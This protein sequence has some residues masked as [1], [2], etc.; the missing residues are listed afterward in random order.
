MK[1]TKWKAA[2]ISTGRDLKYLRSSVFSYLKKRKFEVI[3]YE[4]TGYPVEPSVSAHEACIVAL[5]ECDI[6]IL[7]IDK[8]YGTFFLDENIS[9]TETEYN[10][11]AKL[12]KIIIP[13]INQKADQ[14]RN[15]ILKAIKQIKEKKG[16]TE[17]KAK[18]LVSPHYVDSWNVIDFITN[19]YDADKDN[20][21]IK[22]ST[23]DDLLPNLESRLKGL[24]RAIYTKC[25]ESQ[26][27][28]IKRQK[29]VTLSL[30]LDDIIN[31]GY[32][33]EPEYEVQSGVEKGGLLQD[34]N[35]GKSKQHIM[36]IGKPGLGKSTLLSKSF[37][38]NAEQCLNDKSTE[39]PIYI[40][41][42]G[43]GT[44][45]HFDYNKFN[46]EYFKL[47][48]GKEIYP[49]LDESK[50]TRLFYIDGFDEISEI[51]SS[52]DRDLINSSLF[53]AEPF[54]LCIRTRFA[55]KVVK[56]LSIDDKCD[57]IIKLLPWHKEKAWN[58]I[59][60][61]CRIRN[62]E[63]L[64]EKIYDSYFDND[65]L[66][67]IFESPLFIMMFLMLIEEPSIKLPLDKIN[68]VFLYSEFINQW[69]IRE[70]IRAGDDE[71]ESIKRDIL[72][73]L[74]FTAWYFYKSRFE[75]EIHFVNKEKI[76]EYLSKIDSNLPSVISK[77]AF[78]SLLDIKP[79]T[80]EINGFIHE[81]FMEYLIAEKFIECSYTKDYPFKEYLGY[82]I[83]WE[84]NRLIKSIWK[85]KSLEYLRIILD[86]LWSFYEE[87]VHSNEKSNLAIRNHIMYYIGRLPIKE[88]KRKL[89]IADDIE[90]DVF[91]KLSIAFGLIKL[92]DYKK[93]D[94]FYTLLKSDD[95]FDKANRGYHLVYYR[96]WN[97]KNEQP[98]YLDTGQHKWDA[99][100][101]ALRNHL[102]SKEPRHL[103]LRRVEYFTLKRFIEV[104]KK[105][106]PLSKEDLKLFEN[107][108]TDIENKDFRDKAYAEFKKLKKVWKKYLSK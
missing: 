107:A 49:L 65:E 58:Y 93:E 104:R 88:A 40:S 102:L 10:E 34:C 86:N 105:S 55:E 95:L 18:T 16:I 62:K 19:V 11:S 63:K 38:E 1:V 70:I 59:E 39:I 71:L 54:V 90:K 43:R 15:T 47:Y 22:F 7:L 77:Q 37:I 69:I 27:K 12:G 42:R 51:P 60:E 23:Q 87:I 103:T 101:Q 79:Y 85:I 84:I 44:S 76:S 99:T 80:N 67:D 92:S 14:D 41:L 21:V 82:E 32:F 81:Q 17:D 53:F 66:R 31:K 97:I 73:A 9:I 5:K 29:T 46:N 8:S 3:A 50:I 100:F 68:I 56:K 83:R 106:E 36:L 4:K 89:L 57:L 45:Y 13:C 74:K 25:L 30:S 20:W 26:V 75:S 2:I 35:I 94:E 28:A 64:Y 33:I 91:V 61:Y 96:D 6:I 78:T 72:D 98:P 52:L 108:I 24:T 48:I